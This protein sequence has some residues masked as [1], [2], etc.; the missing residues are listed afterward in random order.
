M[1]YVFRYDLNVLLSL[2]FDII[3]LL[4]FYLFRSEYMGNVDEIIFLMF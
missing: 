1:V 4:Y 3:I 2:C